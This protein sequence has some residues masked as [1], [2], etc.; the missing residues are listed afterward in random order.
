MEVLVY[1]CDMLPPFAYSCANLFEGSAATNLQLIS[2]LLLF[3]YKCRYYD[4]NLLEEAI[5]VRQQVK[6][7]G[8]L[9]Y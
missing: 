5:K 6:A 2:F 1:L 8:N 7:H 4:S 9:F 3:L